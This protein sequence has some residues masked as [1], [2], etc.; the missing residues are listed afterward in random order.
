MALG[1][2]FQDMGMA[3]ADLMQKFANAGV[4]IE[5]VG[6]GTRAFAEATRNALDNRKLC[7]CLQ[8][9]VLNNKDKQ[10]DKHEEMHKYNLQ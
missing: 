8:V 9:E 1:V 4:A 5:D 3:T 7:L 6:V 10:K 2:S